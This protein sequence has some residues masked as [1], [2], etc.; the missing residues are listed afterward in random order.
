ML[1]KSLWHG[2]TPQN[3]TEIAPFSDLPHFGSKVACYAVHGPNMSSLFVMLDALA[4]AVVAPSPLI[5]RFAVSNSVI[6]PI[7]LRCKV[8]RFYRTNFYI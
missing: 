6:N 8:C 1:A 3:S 7:S 5:T 2:I 4:S